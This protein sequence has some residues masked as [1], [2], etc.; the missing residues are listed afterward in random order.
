MQKSGWLKRAAILIALFSCAPAF[1]QGLSAAVVQEI[2]EGANTEFNVINT[3]NSP[4]GS[5]DVNA[6]AVTSTSGGGDPSTT[7]LGWTAETLDAASWSQP[8]GGSGSALPTWQDYTG[9]AYTTEFPTDPAEVNAYVTASASGDTITYGDSLDGF[10]FQGAPDADDHFVLIRN[11]DPNVIVE[12]Q[13][14]TISGTVEVVPEPNGLS[15]CLL[16]VCSVMMFRLRS[17]RPSPEC[18]SNGSQSAKNSL[19][20]FSTASR[21]SPVRF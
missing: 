17:R 4:F 3:S 7:D 5:F 15:L 14:L 16:A 9:K 6:F 13:Q 8:M 18:L 12:G 1:C 20:A 19:T 11:H 10:F 21:V 2:Q